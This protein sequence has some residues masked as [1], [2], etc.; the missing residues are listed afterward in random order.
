MVYSFINSLH[1]HPNHQS[2][3]LLHYLHQKTKTHKLIK[4]KWQKCTTCSNSLQDI[5]EQKDTSTTIIT[6][7]QPNVT[8]AP[9]SNSN[10]QKDNESISSFIVVDKKQDE[11]ILELQSII[12]NLKSELES[13]KATNQALQK[14][15]QGIAWMINAYHCSLTISYVAVA[16]DLDY[17]EMSIDEMLAEKNNLAQQLEEEKVK[18][19]IQQLDIHVSIIRSRANNI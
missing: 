12:E 1:L 19:L 16:K 17:F 10:K 2:K 14:Q 6:T 13:E 8:L 18:L 5:A 15:K 11:E 3:Q 4:V 9:Y 7:E